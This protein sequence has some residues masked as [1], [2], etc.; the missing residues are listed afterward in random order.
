MKCAYCGK[1]SRNEYCAKHL[2]M[3]QDGWILDGHTWISG[4]VAKTKPM[5]EASRNLERVLRANKNRSLSNLRAF[6]N[7][8]TWDYKFIK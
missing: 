4:A 2:R 3:L 7:G 8:K 1:R 6:H 5:T